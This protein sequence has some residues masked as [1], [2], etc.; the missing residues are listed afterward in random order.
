MRFDAVIFDLDGVICSTDEYHYKAWKAMADGM[1]I[2]FD[3]TRLVDR[4]DKGLG[5]GLIQRSEYPEHGVMRDLFHGEIL[6]RAHIP[7][8]RPVHQGDGRAAGVRKV[9]GGEDR[10]DRAHRPGRGKGDFHALRRHPVDPFRVEA[11]QPCGGV[12]QRPVKIGKMKR[13]HKGS[14]L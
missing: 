1:G 8:H 13:R 10:R 3:R 9:D 4:V 7:D 2:P 5:S 6:P 14:S 12:Q 11:G